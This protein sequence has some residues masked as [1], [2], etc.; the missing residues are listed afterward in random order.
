MSSKRKRSNKG[1]KPKT[2]SKTKEAKKQPRCSVSECTKQCDARYGYCDDHINGY[3]PVGRATGLRC[4][5]PSLS[6]KGRKRTAH[7]SHPFICQAHFNEREASKAEMKVVAED[8]NK[9]Y[10]SVATPGHAMLCELERLQLIPEGMDRYNFKLRVDLLNNVYNTWKPPT[11]TTSGGDSSSSSLSSLAASSTSDTKFA[12]DLQEYEKLWQPYVS[13]R[14]C[15]LSRWC[16]ETLVHVKAF[17]DHGRSK[18]KCGVFDDE[19]IDLGAA[20]ASSHAE[21]ISS[22]TAIPRPPP[23]PCV[24]TTTA[25]PF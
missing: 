20:M 2:P 1:T 13:D 19:A 25:S 14:L 3:C 12:R 23:P 18:C 22:P 7:S 9:P 4:G 16:D 8:L 10:M 24:P 15:R 11:A 6:P 21:T 17:M 5:Q